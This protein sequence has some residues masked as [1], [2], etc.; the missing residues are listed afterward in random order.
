MQELTPCL[1]TYALESDH[2]PQLSHP[3]ALTELFLKAV[4]QN[5]R[6]V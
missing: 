5:A 6:A 1:A 3:N 4:A 2:A